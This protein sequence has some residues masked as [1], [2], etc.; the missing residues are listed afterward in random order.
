MRFVE[1][2]NGVRGIRE[3]GATTQGQIGQHQIVIG[4]YAVD[5]DPHDV[6]RVDRDLAVV[7][8]LET[9]VC[10]LGQALSKIMKVCNLCVELRLAD[11]GR[12]R[13]RD[14]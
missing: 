12:D 13:D 2:I 8:H 3:Y 6:L 7:S 4:D 10:E 9:E 5:L 14:R 11:G 1:D